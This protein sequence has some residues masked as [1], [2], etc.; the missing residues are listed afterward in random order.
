MEQP[1]YCPDGI[2]ELMQL[3]WLEDPNQRLDFSEITKRLGRYLGENVLSHYVDLNIP[4]E[5]TNLVENEGY[6]QIDSNFSNQT[7]EYLNDILVDQNETSSNNNYVNEQIN[8]YLNEDQI[9]QEKVKIIDFSTNSSMINHTYT[10][11]NV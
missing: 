8:G 1:S 4:Y 3:C 6:L 2:Y 7:E 10:N 5:Q 9:K 11:V